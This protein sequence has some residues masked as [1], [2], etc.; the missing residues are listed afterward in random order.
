MYFCGVTGNGI[1]F[2]S[3]LQVTE[4]VKYT[5]VSVNYLLNK[6]SLNIFR[7]VTKVLCK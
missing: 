4:M 2:F 3:G 6:F 7:Q 5:E 1:D